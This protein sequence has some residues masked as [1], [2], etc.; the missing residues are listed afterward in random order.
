MKPKL[1]LAQ[2]YFF[3]DYFP[4]GVILCYHINKDKQKSGSYMRVQNIALRLCKNCH[5]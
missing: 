4:N 2:S 3:S 1:L 5:I